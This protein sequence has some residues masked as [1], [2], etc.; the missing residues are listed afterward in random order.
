V[1]LVPSGPAPTSEKIR[2]FRLGVGYELTRRIQLA[3]GWDYGTR[4]SDVGAREYDYN[5][6]SFNARWVF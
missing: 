4:S 2:L 5:A 3:A 6:L 1:L